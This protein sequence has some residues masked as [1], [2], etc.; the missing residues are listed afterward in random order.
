MPR[1]PRAALATCWRACARVCW[2]RGAPLDAAR[3]AVAAHAMAAERSLGTW[4]ADAAGQ[5]PAR[6]PGRAASWPRYSA[7]ITSIFQAPDL[8]GATVLVVAAQVEGHPS[9]RP[10]VDRPALGEHLEQHGQGAAIHAHD[11]DAWAGRGRAARRRPVTIEDLTT[12]GRGQR[13]AVQ[14]QPD[15]GQRGRG[16]MRCTWR[17]ISAMSSSVMGRLGWR[18]ARHG[19]DRA[20]RRRGRSLADSPPH[21]CRNGRAATAGERR[22]GAGHGCRSRPRA[23]S[24]ADES[25]A[26]RG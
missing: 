4:L 1:W 14:Q 20:W 11:G 7:P 18:G 21:G 17:S 8:V 6:D 26:T 9:S 3:L 10:A 23:G 24:T 5:R 12:R 13:D 15:A 22:G 25:P 16:Q 19:L 2:P